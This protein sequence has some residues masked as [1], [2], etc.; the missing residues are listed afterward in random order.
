MLKRR[1][2]QAIKSNARLAAAMLSMII[3]LCALCVLNSVSA[4]RVQ[5]IRAA[6]ADAAVQL[7]KSRDSARKSKQQKLTEPLRSTRAAAFRTALNALI[8]LNEQGISE[9]WQAALENPSPEL[10]RQAWNEYRKIW[11]ALARNESVPRVVRLSASSD[12]VE[13]IFQGAQIDGAVWLKG[14]SETVAAVPPYSLDRLRNA[15]VGYN[16]LFD[17][18]SDWE[19]AR[20]NGDRGALEITPA[21]QTASAR[22]ASR[23]RIAVIDVARKTS[24]TQGYSDWL[25]D[26]EDIISRN[27]SYLALLDIF[28]SD[29]STQSLASHVQERYTRRGYALAGFFTAE[30][31]AS[32]MGRFFPG[33]SFDPG[34]ALGGAAGGEINPALMN[35]RFHSYQSTL[36]EFTQLAAARP[37]IAQLVNLGPS[38]EGRQIFGLKISRE[39][40]TNDP[41][42]PDI[43]ITGCHHAREW[44]SVEPP[45]YFANKLINGY[46]TDASMRYLVDHLQVWII[47]IM[48]P[49]GLNFSQSSG[50]NQLDAIRMWRKNRRPI[51]GTGCVDGTGVDLNR[52]YNHQ[53]R[54]DGDSPCPSF[55]DDVGASDDPSNEVYRGSAPNSELEV[56][57]I[58]LLTGDPN[59][60]F[61][62]RIDYHNFSELILY[63]WGYQYGTADDHTTLSALAKRMSD[64]VLDTGREYY[65]PEQSIY[66]YITT[67]SSIDYSYGIDHVPA[68]FVVEVRPNCCGFNVPESEIT[69]VNEENWAGARMILNWAAGPP[70]LRSVRA[71]QQTSDGAFSKL[72]Y[73]AHWT[74][75]PN[76]RQLIVD[77][78]FPGLV[79]G[80][81]QIQLGF[82]KP[83]DASS[84]PIASLGRGGAFDELIFSVADPSEGWKKS[85]YENDLWIGEVSIAGDDDHSRQWRL[86]AAALDAVPLKLDAKPA[87]AATY[88]YG[89]NQW[90]FDEDASGQDGEGGIDLNHI[91]S[92][93][94]RGDELVIYVASPR[95]GERYAGGDSYTAS[96]SLPPAST[97]FVPGPQELLLSTD[98]GLTFSSLVSGLAP[99]A[100]KATVT[101]PRIATGTARLRVSARD[102]RQQS[103]SVLGD[104]ESGFTI[105]SNVGAGVDVT[106]TSSQLIETEWSDPASGLSGS[107]QFY[108]D[109][110]VRNR[111]NAP[112]ANSFVRI[113]D[114]TKGNILLSRDANTNAG[115]GAIQ[116]LNDG[117]DGTLSPG[118]TIQVRLIIGL[119]KRKK[120]VVSLNAYG[121]PASPI[122][123]SEP[124]VVWQA[125]PR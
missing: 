47:P 82:S 21:Y 68:P 90:R 89:A 37:D 7:I 50:N 105:G 52:N 83:M 27:D 2:P 1:L 100:A 15:G 62:S 111:G 44:I 48:N 73:S 123:E 42:K 114:L 30:E 110:V 23:I 101:M 125:K 77:S 79:P 41:S 36:N 20:N 46:D 74:D 16:V 107:A 108:I 45:V 87:T 96:W 75:Q 34:N 35:G 93:G 33:K 8:R 4:N 103:A 57:A 67:G 14:E 12:A 80:R 60:H 78:R 39:V 115:S 118:E 85:V 59:R 72:V 117:G 102:A 63:P 53:W 95:G 13:R 32:Q 25:G 9:V 109:L 97:G 104:S 19:S 124:A 3:V 116:S 10:R 84:N 121:V 51:M 112:I 69:P 94:I 106:T 88:T 6:D 5:V 38:Y 29:G 113:V 86:S 24:P 11:P 65:N 54:L 70:I 31:F 49:D 92:P 91:L 122:G 18:V 71:F 120:F 81:L 17:S 61:R 119:V 76:A 28:A 66:L 98:G 22:K 55:N 56:R 43:L 26:A 64:L 40:A 58:N 99:N